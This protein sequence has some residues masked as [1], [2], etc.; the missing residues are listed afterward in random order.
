MAMPFVLF[1]PQMHIDFMK[2][3]FFSNTVQMWA[4]SSEKQISSLS[5]ELL[6]ERLVPLTDCFQNI[7]LSLCVIAIKNIR[8]RIKI[9]TQCSVISVILKTYGFYDHNCMQPLLYDSDGPAFIGNHITIIKFLSSLIFR[10]AIHFDTSILDHK[11]C[12]H[13]RTYRTGSFQCPGQV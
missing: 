1:F 3:P 9:Q 4:S 8:I 5:F 12:I 2:N 11:L 10:L 13:A 7:G 6:C